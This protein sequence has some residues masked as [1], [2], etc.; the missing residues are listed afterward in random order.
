[1]VT[2]DGK[3]WMVD[4]DTVEPTHMEEEKA[5]KILDAYFADKPIVDAGELKEAI[6][7]ILFHYRGTQQSLMYMSQELAAFR[8]KGREFFTCHDCPDNE[9]CPSRWDSYNT[10]G[11]CLEDK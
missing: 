1:M 7:S 9:T 5:E 4:W 11:D 3:D 6:R 2:E 10:D 8:G